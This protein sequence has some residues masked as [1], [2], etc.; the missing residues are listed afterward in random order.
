[1]NNGKSEKYGIT[2]NEIEQKSLSS[3]KFKTLFNIHRIER[4]RHASDNKKPNKKKSLQKQN[5]IKKVPILA[6]KRVKNG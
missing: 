6:K 3:E 2:P 5:F 4:S 1:M